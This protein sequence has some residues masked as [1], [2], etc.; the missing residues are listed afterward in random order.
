MTPKK[1]DYIISG[2][3]VFINRSADGEVYATVHDF[4]PFGV[5]PLKVV[6][7]P[8]TPQSTEESILADPIVQAA[9]ARERE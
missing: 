5:E 1:L 8:L 9:I 6:R 3:K 4:S 2:A 7:V